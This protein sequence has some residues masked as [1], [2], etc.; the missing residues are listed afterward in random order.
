MEIRRSLLMI[1]PIIFAVVIP[2][3]CPKKNENTQAVNRYV[4]C[5][6]E[7]TVVGPGVSFRPRDSIVTLVKPDSLRFEIS[8]GSPWVDTRWLAE[9][10]DVASYW[11][12]VDV[13]ISLDGDARVSGIDGNENI[14]WPAIETIIDQWHY[15]ANCDTGIVRFDFSSTGDTVISNTD[16]LICTKGL[17]IYPNH[18]GLLHHIRV[19]LF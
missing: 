5:T 16:S 10:L 14:V 8:P 12:R 4:G 3:C 7:D 9:S 19:V 6:Y 2:G 11:V 1:L 17:S 13:H 18:R 15:P